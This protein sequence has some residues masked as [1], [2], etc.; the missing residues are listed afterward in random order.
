M[1]FQHQL[2]FLLRS[3][4]GIKQRGVSSQELPCLSNWSPLIP[5]FQ[6]LQ[7][8]ENEKRTRLV[9]FKLKCFY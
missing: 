3:D 5:L 9:A 4:K 2:S 1:I 7:N 6:I 8:S